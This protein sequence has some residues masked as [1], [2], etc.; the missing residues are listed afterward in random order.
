MPVD[1]PAGLIVVRREIAD[2]R[3]DY[4]IDPA[5]DHACVRRSRSG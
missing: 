5:K 4:W 1:V 2:K 3:T